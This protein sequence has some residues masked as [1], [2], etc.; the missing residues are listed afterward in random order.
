MSALHLGSLDQL[1]ADP[2]AAATVSRE[3]ALALLSHV[4]LIQAALV[5]RLLAAQA[6]N[7]GADTPSPDPPERLLTPEEAAAR[8]GV[9]RRYLYRH[10]KAL[11]FARRLSRKTLRFDARGL[12]KWLAARR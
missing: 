12:A 4:A 8:L 9:T 5:A 10:A 11:P 7:A 2:R 3:T 6:E 1:A